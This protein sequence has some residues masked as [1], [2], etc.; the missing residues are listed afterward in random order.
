MKPLVRTAAAALALAIA[1]ATLSCGRGPDI[2]PLRIAAAADLRFVLDDIVALFRRQGAEPACAITYASS[3]SLFAQLVNRAPFDVYL[4]A[5]VEYVRQLAARDLV[6]PGSAFT[7]GFGRLVVWVP[8]SSS[9]E[10]DRLGLKAL[11]APAVARV[12]IA[13]PEHAPYGRAAEAAMRRADVYEAVRGKLVS[14]DNVS[15]ALQFVESGAAQA[16]IVSLSLALAP[17][18]AAGGRFVEVPVDLYPPIEQGG[19]ILRWAANPAAARRF[20]AV[21]LSEAGRTVLRQHGLA[22]RS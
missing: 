1:G 20:R 22:D 14:G 19:A 3:G 11:E 21:L 6:A 8:A 13:S 9:L 15:Q 10:I 12:A 2:Q 4:S 18:A 5:D 7:Y 16:G 17:H